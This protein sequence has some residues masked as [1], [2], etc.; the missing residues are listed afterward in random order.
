ME[1]QLPAA[2]FT[3]INAQRSPRPHHAAAARERDGAH[4]CFQSG[5]G[6][7]LANSP[8]G[9]VAAPIQ[10]MSSVMYA[11]SKPRVAAEARSPWNLPSCSTKYTRPTTSTRTS[12]LA[13]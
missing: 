12:S 11:S 9:S 8:F 6:G 3:C 13:R 2:P 7:V 5:A 1:R 4:T 10:M